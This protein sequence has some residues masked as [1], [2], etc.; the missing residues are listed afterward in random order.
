MVMQISKSRETT[1][2]EES[3]LTNDI[4]AIQQ[5]TNYRLDIG[6][7]DSGVQAKRWKIHWTE[8]SIV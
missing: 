8:Q 4:N 2:S 1:Q 7:V 3:L 6:H 5:K